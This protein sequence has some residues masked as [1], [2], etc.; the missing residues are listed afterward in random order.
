MS[1]T[2]D[3]QALLDQVAN[4]SKADKELVQDLAAKMPEMLDVMSNLANHCLYGVAEYLIEKSDLTNKVEIFEYLTKGLSKNN[5]VC[6]SE[7]FYN[8]NLEEEDT[9][10]I[11]INVTDRN[12]DLTAHLAKVEALYSAEQMKGVKHICSRLMS[13]V[14][15]YYK[16]FYVTHIEFMDHMN[17]C[18]VLKIDPVKSLFYINYDDD[19]RIGLFIS[20]ESDKE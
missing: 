20:F 9:L 14:H 6:H 4:L 3:E 12:H 10:Y 7:K 15:L 1:F 2:E 16:K 17:A 8:R 5:I 13:A 19:F 18:E 11:N